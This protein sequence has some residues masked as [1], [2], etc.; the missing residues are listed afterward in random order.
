MEVKSEWT[1][2][3]AHA[4]QEK[5]SW[6]AGWVVGV[7]LVEWDS[8]HMLTYTHTLL[9]RHSQVQVNTL[10]EASPTSRVACVLYTDRERHGCMCLVYHRCAYV[11]A[12]SC[13]RVRVC[14]CYLDMARAVTVGL[15]LF[16]I[17]W[18]WIDFSSR[19]NTRYLSQLWPWPDIQYLH[20]NDQYNNSLKSVIP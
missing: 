15:F 16:C 4:V 17:V 20:R 14:V 12:R 13:V 18:T 7:L 19:H 6:S 8:T 2:V 9:P 11:C 1:S 3:C 5:S 10:P